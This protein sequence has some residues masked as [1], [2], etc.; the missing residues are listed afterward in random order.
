MSIHPNGGARGKKSGSHQSRLDLSSRE[1]QVCTKFHINLSNNCRPTFP[2]RGSLAR[3]NI[4]KKTK[5]AL[6][7]HLHSCLCHSLDA[8]SVLAACC[9]IRIKGGCLY[10]MVHYVTG[11]PRIVPVCPARHEASVTFR[12]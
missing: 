9:E 11:A 7:L 10:E 4:A 2:F 8:D 12:T 6:E 1:H 5:R 3:C